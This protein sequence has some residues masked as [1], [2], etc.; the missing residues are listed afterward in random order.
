MRVAIVGSSGRHWTPKQRE[1]ACKKIKDILTDEDYY[2][3]NPGDPGDITF[4]TFI[5]GGCPKGGVDI[6]A[7]IIADFIGLDKRIHY[8]ENNLWE[9]NGYKKRNEKI[10]RDC[11]ALFCIDPDNRGWSGGRYTMKRADF[12]G[13]ETH[14]IL[15]PSDNNE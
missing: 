11:D 15:I 1:L 13:K 14:L 8:P 2:D 12:Y 7:E 6:W 4:P 10:A 3:F 9:P 5:S